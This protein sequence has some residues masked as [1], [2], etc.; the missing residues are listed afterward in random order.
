M[1]PT[2]AFFIG[3][4][5]GAVVALVCFIGWVMSLPDEEEDAANNS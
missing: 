5:V 2:M 1:S 3:C 4:G